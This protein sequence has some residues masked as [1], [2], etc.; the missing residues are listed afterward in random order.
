MVLNAEQMV[1]EVFIKELIIKDECKAN[2]FTEI[3]SKVGF[4]A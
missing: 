2:V 3:R 4:K 1:S